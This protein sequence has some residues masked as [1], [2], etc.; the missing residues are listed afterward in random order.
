MIQNKL[1]PKIVVF[2]KIINVHAIQGNTTFTSSYLN[3]LTNWNEKTIIDAAI[4]II[5][6]PKAIHKTDFLFSR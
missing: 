3:S 6:I 2:K 5:L 1:K 4:K